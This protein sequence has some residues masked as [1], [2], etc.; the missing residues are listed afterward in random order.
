MTNKPSCRR[1]KQPHSRDELI[2]VWIGA[3]VVFFLAI[4][5]LMF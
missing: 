2:T 4:T 5:D 3:G 1:R